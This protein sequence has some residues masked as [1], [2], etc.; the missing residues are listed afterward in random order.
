MLELS[1]VINVSVSQAPVGLGE[2]NVNN[3]G[4]FT[5]EN[6]LHVN[7]G[8]YGVYVSPQAVGEDFGTTSETYKQAVA[9]FSQQP[10]ILA[11]GGNLII[12]PRSTLG[13]SSSSSS[14]S[15]SSGASGPGA[16]PLVQAIAE[17]APLIYFCGI[18]STYYPTAQQDMEDLATAVQAYGDKI[19]FLPSATYADV[20]GAF[21]A[22]KNASEYATRCIYYNGVGTALGARLMAA[23]YAGR[24]MSVEFGASNTVNTMNLKSLVGVIP[25]ETIT[26]TIYAALEAAGVDAYV[27]YA[28][29]PSVVSNGENHYFD[30]I[31]NL[32]W[33]VNQLKVNGFNALKQIPNKIPQTE[34]GMNLLK[35]AY[36]DA[37]EQ[38][39]ANGYVA[40]GTWTSPEYF[41]NQENMIQNIEQR[42]YY[43]YSTPIS[44]QS[45]ADRA[46]RKAPLVQIAVKEAGA[47]HSSNIVVNVNP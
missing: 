29:I 15:S 46:A 34:P 12:F 6:P 39:L 31:Y 35:S 22:I 27:S 41:G 4:L 10:N 30:E 32:I 24:A 5:D 7:Y 40:P 38:A 26:Q 21:T 45:T 47:I 14:S 44:Q 37:C 13:P 3:I 23:A 17:A 11:G 28:G 42:G 16:I 9:I 25:D 18:L 19:L 2:F 36:R 20:A 8:P 33:F 1:N 43:I